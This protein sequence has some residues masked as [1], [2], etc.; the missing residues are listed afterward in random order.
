MS[1]TFVTNVLDLQAC[2]SHI[3]PVICELA[4]TE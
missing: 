2:D 1:C 3:M 4:G